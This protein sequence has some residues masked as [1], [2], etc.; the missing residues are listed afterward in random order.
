MVF[1]KNGGLQIINTNHPSYDPFMFPSGHFGW[2]PQSIKLN[3]PEIDEIKVFTVQNENPEIDT[4]VIDDVNAIE[5]QQLISEEQIDIDY[6]DDS[7]ENFSNTKKMRFVSAMQYYAYLL[8]D[9]PNSYI[10]YDSWSM[11]SNQQ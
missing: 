6:K 10:H 4:D 1:K 9:R 3:I 2:S 11:W 5:E 8:C 7:E